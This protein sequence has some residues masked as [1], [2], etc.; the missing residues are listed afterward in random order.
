M[1]GGSVLNEGFLFAADAKYR[2]GRTTR[3][4]KYG[5]HERRDV[6]IENG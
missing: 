2:S 6:V 3:R 4:A 1:V 5:S